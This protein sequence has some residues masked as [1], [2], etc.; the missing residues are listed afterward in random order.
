MHPQTVAI[1]K[2]TAVH[3]GGEVHVSQ[4]VPALAAVIDWGEGRK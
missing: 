2:L 4:V 1:S 3:D